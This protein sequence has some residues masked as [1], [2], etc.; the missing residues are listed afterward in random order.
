[1]VCERLD[2][3]GVTYGP[4]RNPFVPLCSPYAGRNPYDLHGLRR[5]LF[6]TVS[7]ILLFR[8]PG[9]FLIVV[10]TGEKSG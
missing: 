2:S 9:I 6:Y 7:F 4:Y 8:L 5:V 10:T 3:G 1:M